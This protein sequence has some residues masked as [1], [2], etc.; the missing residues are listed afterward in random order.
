MLYLVLGNPLMTVMLMGAPFWVVVEEHPT[1][2]HSRTRRAMQPGPFQFLMTLRSSLVLS[3]SLSSG[4]GEAG[5]LAGA[6]AAGAEE[7]E[8]AGDAVD[9]VA[10]L[11][12]APGAGAADVAALAEPAV[13]LAGSGLGVSLLHAEKSR[14]RAMIPRVGAVQMGMPAKVHKT[15]LAV[16]PISVGVRRCRRTA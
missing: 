14:P 5:G 15:V 7:G 6:T 8:E 13:S 4:S 10:A 9:S 12:A 1:R 11:W 16:K 3:H 2:I